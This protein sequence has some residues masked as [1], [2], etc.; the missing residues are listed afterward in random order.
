VP[1]SQPKQKAMAVRQPS[2]FQSSNTYLGQI[3]D[4]A[5]E[6]SAIEPN[7]GHAPVHVTADEYAEPMAHHRRQVRRKWHPRGILL[8]TSTHSWDFRVRSCHRPEPWCQMIGFRRKTVTLK[9]LDQWIQSIVESQIWSN[10]ASTDTRRRP[11]V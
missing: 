6:Y 2:T 1:L 9:S 5:G 4:C 10:L 11:L 3:D 8:T 7:Q